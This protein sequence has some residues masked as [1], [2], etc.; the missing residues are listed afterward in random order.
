MDEVMRWSS[1][2]MSRS[3]EPRA[4]HQ[5]RCL[6]KGAAAADRMTRDVVDGSQTRMR[7]LFRR[8][9]ERAS[10]P[11]RIRILVNLKEQGRA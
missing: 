8:N 11:H 5:R 2:V 10:E 3:I 7:G 9:K 1:Q 4:P 6:L